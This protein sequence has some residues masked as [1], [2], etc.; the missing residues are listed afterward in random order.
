MENIFYSIIIPHHNIPHLL[1]RCLDSIPQR[2]DMEIVIVDD[3]SDPHIVDFDHFPGKERQDTI[4]IL[5]K[6]GGGGGYARNLALQVIKGKKVLFADADDYFNPC[7]SEI[8]N[9]YRDDDTADIVFFKA[10]SVY[11]NTYLP[12]ERHQLINSW[13]DEYF[14]NLKQGELSLRYRFGGPVCKLIKRSLITDNHIS[15]DET[16]IHNDTRFSYLI[17]FHAQRIKADNRALYMITEREGSTCRVQSVENSMVRIKVFGE[18]ALFL[19]NHHIPVTEELHIKQ[20]ISF[21][22]SKDKSL[23][24]KAMKMLSDMGHRPVELK[25]Q[26]VRKKLWNQLYDIK[27]LWGLI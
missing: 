13:N 23:Y 27:H 16:P 20:L 14:H 3:N 1:K 21:Q 15:F 19:L 6:K 12:A 11:T 10:N 25:K 22:K 26:L 18:K 17:G 7:L 8:L 4:I 5:D 24:P 9:D 2:Q